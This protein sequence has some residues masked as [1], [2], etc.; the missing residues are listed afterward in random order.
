MRSS[1]PTV[2]VIIRCFN[3]V[4]RLP[5]FLGRLRAL[6]LDPRTTGWQFLVVDDGST[7]N[8]FAALLQAVRAESWID[9]VRLHEHL[10]FGAVIRMG[11]A[12][13]VAEI[14]CTIDADC[15]FA[16]EQLPELAQVIDGGADIAIAS[17]HSSTNGRD[18]GSPLGLPLP[19]RVPAIYRQFVWQNIR[20]IMSPFRAYRRRVLESIQFRSNGWS[21]V[22]EISLKAVLAGYHV[23]ELPMPLERRRPDESKLSI[24]DAMVARAHLFGLTVLEVCRQQ[25]RQALGRDA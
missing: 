11:F 12:H 1:P 21:A 17:A 4:D 18:D 2:A 3:Q 19:Q 13:T 7:D 23:C 10:G 15:R 14:V 8:S 25:A 22:A 6:H 5:A 16:L 20:A 24:G 9:V